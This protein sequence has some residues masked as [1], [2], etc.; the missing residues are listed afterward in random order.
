MG[1]QPCHDFFQALVGPNGNVDA[2]MKQVATTAGQIASGGYLYD[3]RSSKTTLDPE[4]F[5][6][7]AYGN[8]D[9]VGEYF[10]DVAGRE[11]LSQFNGLAIWLRPSDWGSFGPMVEFPGGSANWYGL[12]TLMHE[13]LHKEMIG[14]GFTHEQIK[15]AL[16]TSLIA[17]SWNKNA[18]S[19]SLGKICF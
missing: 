14:G 7:T 11:A 19:A 4:K 15:S 13:I 9:T 2:L 6:N 3:G 18:I 12:G 10:D 16:S 5:P 8:V 17:E 1:K